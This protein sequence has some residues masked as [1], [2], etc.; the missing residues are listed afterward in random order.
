[1]ANKLYVYKLSVYPV[2]SQYNT[3]MVNVPSPCVSSSPAPRLSVHE[4]LSPW[5]PPPLYLSLPPLPEPPARSTAPCLSG[6]G[7]TDSRN[8]AWPH[9]ARTT[10]HHPILWASLDLEP[11]S[12]PLP[13]IGSTT[14][15]I[16]DDLVLV[17][18]TSRANKNEKCGSFEQ[19]ISKA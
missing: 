18:E 2:K 13:L 7:V 10:L 6:R 14:C 9:P 4:P 5:P 17:D 12:E 1:M 11:R 3:H 19:H 8:P 16:K 15:R